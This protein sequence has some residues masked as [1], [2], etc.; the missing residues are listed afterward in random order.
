MTN[1]AACSGLPSRT[2]A[3]MTANSRCFQVDPQQVNPKPRTRSVASLPVGLMAGIVSSGGSGHN[4]RVFSCWHSYGMTRS[5][6][7]V[8]FAL[9][10]SLHGQQRIATGED[11]LGERVET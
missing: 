8:L 5:T 4:T 1:A 3:P 11:A 2:S 6:H 7:L 9:A 10:F